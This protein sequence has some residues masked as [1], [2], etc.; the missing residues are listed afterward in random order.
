MCSASDANSSAWPSRRGNGIEAASSPV[1]PAANWRAAREQAGR[2]R[3]HANA[4]LRQ[5]ARDWQRH[6][7]DA[8]LRAE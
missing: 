7:D 5:F 2:D 3:Q 6:G 8:A 1:L 4:E